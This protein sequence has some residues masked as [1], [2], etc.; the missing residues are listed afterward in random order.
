MI[1]K[2][3]K[4]F[5][6]EQLFLA[7]L[8][9]TLG[10]GIAHYLGYPIK[11]GILIVGFLASISLQTTGLFLVEYFQLPMLPLGTNESFSQREKVRQNILIISL[12]TL[13]LSLTLIFEMQVQHLLSL[14]AGIFFAL[15]LVLFIIFAVP[16]VRLATRG[17]GELVLAF[18]LGAFLPI[19]AFIVESG[20]FHRL[21]AF[22]TLA[23]PL[24]A[25]AFFIIKDFTTFTQDQKNCR[26]TFLV[27]ITW[28]RAV[29]IHHLLVLIPFV[30]FLFAP[31]FN[32]P[33]GIIWPVFIAF[34]FAIG[35]IILLQ[36]IANGGRAL[37]NVLTFLALVSF[38]LP[39]YL[40]TI[41]FWVH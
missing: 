34:P 8:T 18:Y 27:R 41:T 16:P 20:I 32:F 23:L 3:T 35:Q 39:V 25:L 29:P 37:W 38:G 30:F 5:P 26:S 24:L 33:R 4:L 19:F 13:A 14:P 10:V 31:S 9:Y 28:Q 40:L 22:T 6:I 1:L 17:F 15:M 36:S 2:Y 11:I 21:L 7:A 12:G